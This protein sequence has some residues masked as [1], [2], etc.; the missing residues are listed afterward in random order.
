[1]CIR[2]SPRSAEENPSPWA[3]CP[4]RRWPAPPCRR[5]EPPP[6]HAPGAPSFLFPASTRGHLNQYSLF[7]TSL[8]PLSR[9]TGYTL[10]RYE[11]KL[12]R[13]SAKKEKKKENRRGEKRET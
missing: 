3:C 13:K 12:S 4:C 9:F 11:R 5:S 10:V 8:F 7:Q 2:G 1:M 6:N